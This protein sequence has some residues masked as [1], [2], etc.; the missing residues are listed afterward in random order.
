MEGSPRFQLISHIETQGLGLNKQNLTTTK[1]HHTFRWV[2]CLLLILLA[3]RAVEL[4][5]SSI[6]LEPPDDEEELIIKQRSKTKVIKYVEE[7]PSKDSVCTLLNSSF[8]S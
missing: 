6:D 5:L 3:Y 2:N 8:L 1:C 7:K 4:G